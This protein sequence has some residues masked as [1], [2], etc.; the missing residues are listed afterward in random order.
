M[1]KLLSMMAIP[2]YCLGLFSFAGQFY[3][4]NKGLAITLA[5]SP[6]WLLIT[7]LPVQL[8]AGVLKK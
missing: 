7:P 6:L 1:L 8:F 4:Q 3:E 5:V 2:M